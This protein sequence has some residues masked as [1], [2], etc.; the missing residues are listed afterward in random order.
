MRTRDTHTQRERE[1]HVELKV[2]GDFELASSTNVRRNRLDTDV[3]IK[4]IEN[5]KVGRFGV[6]PET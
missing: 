6:T 4:Q 2:S 3:H 1:M 5:S